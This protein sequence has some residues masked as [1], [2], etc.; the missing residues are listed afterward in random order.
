MYSN[1]L[2]VGTTQQITKAIASDAVLTLSI[3]LRMATTHMALDVDV[4]SMLFASHSSSWRQDDDLEKH[5]HDWFMG[6]CRFFFSTKI[7]DWICISRGA[8]SSSSCWHAC[9][10]NKWHHWQCRDAV[11]NQSVSQSISQ[12]VGQEQ[13]CVCMQV[14]K[15]ERKTETSQNEFPH[16]DHTTFSTRQTKRKKKNKSADLSC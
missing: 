3:L 5:R 8:S 14:R 15:K 1:C 4:T 2:Y 13:V 9:Q 10:E 7:A 12:L 11:I 16:K 6:S